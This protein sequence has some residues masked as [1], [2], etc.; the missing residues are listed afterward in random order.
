M[1]AFVGTERQCTEDEHTDYKD[2]NDS[3]ISEFGFNM[4]PASPQKS[5]KCRSDELN[6]GLDLEGS[7]VYL[8]AN[9]CVTPTIGDASR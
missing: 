7:S 8:V 1:G 3:R 9:K 6:C 2:E 4:L 5:R